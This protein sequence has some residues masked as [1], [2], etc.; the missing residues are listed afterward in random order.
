MVWSQPGWVACTAAFLIL[1]CSAPAS[2]PAGAC[3]A[4][5][6]RFH[7]L[8]NPVEVVGTPQSSA[9]GRIEIRYQSTNAENIPVVGRA[10]CG[11]SVGDGGALRLNFGEVDGTELQAAALDGINRSNLPAL[12]P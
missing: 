9:G 8:P 11:F 3:A 1:A 4:V 7:G 10:V 6:K 12:K 2:G 5:V